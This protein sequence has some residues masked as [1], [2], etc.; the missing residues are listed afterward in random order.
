MRDYRIREADWTV[1]C[2]R[3]RGVRE[4]VFVREQGVPLDL[5]YDELDAVSRHVLAESA[6][7]E[8]VGT[9][10]LVPDGHIGRMAV[11]P[12]WR[13]CRVGTGLL[14]ALLS[15]A[16]A[17]GHADVLLNAQTHAQPF[18]ARHGFVVCGAVF[19]EAGIPHRTMRL[20]L[21][22]AD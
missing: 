7:G 17:E 8:P 18:Y 6:Q 16:R 12:G 20:V 5:E 9:G 14:Q 4:A 3:L 1:D 21:Q 15:L 22:P 10:R 11:L 2:A 19:M 13:G